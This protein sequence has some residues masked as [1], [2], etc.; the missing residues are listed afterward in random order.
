MVLLVTAAVGGLAM[1]V[2][3]EPLHLKGIGSLH[4]LTFAH[5]QGPNPSVGNAAYGNPNLATS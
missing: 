2:M 4:T 3:Y 1:T 5:H